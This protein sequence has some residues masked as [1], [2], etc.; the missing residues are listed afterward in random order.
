MFEYQYPQ[1]RSMDA[2]DLA[3]VKVKPWAKSLSAPLKGLKDLL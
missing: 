2:F 1:R 3:T